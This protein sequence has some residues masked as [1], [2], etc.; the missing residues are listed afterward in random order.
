MAQIAG[1]AASHVN[2]AMRRSGELPQ[3]TESELA[4]EK[5]DSRITDW[6]IWGYFAL[7]GLAF[8]APFAALLILFFKLI[9]KHQ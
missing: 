1:T 8:V 7:Y 2:E 9:S 3:K 5:R 6:L 4:K